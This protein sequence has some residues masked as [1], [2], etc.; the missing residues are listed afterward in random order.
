MD[1]VTQILLDNLIKTAQESDRLPWEQPWKNFNTFNWFTKRVYTGINRWLLPFGEYLTM[2]QFRT[3]NATVD[4]KYH[5]VVGSPWFT[6]YFSKEQAKPIPY[7]SLPSNIQDNYTGADGFLGYAGYYYYKCA[8][9]VFYE[10]KRIRRYALVTDRSNFVDASNI[11]LPSKLETGELEITYSVPKDILRAYLDKENIKHVASNNGA[12]YS[13]DRDIIGTPPAKH[14]KSEEQYFATMF[15][16]MAHSTGHERRLN[17]V[18]V[19]G[20]ILKGTKVY[21][22]EEVIAE[23]ASSLL[24]AES[25]IMSYESEN[26]KLYLDHASYVQGYINFLKASEEDIV[27]LCSDAERAFEFII[28]SQSV[29]DVEGDE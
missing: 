26:S 17:R 27:K 20:R 24:C 3:Y 16:E 25:G 29:V 2:H 23:L 10:C 7:S 13:P 5:L 1:K 6:V 4:Y 19:V 9:T 12:W 11:P 22:R 18:G 14:F 21:S 28:G 8:G 15:H